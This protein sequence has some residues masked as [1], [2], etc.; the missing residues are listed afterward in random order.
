[1]D[2]KAKR[3][4][5]LNNRKE[6]RK[7]GVLLAA[8]EAFKKNGID[9]TKISEIANKAEIGVASVYRYFPTKVDLAIAA[10]TY[11]LDDKM[12]SFYHQF[13]DSEFDKHSGIENVRSILNIFL[14][15]Y[16]N[17]PEYI[18]FLENFD[19]YVIK[20]KIDFDKLQ[21]YEQSL[22]DF[23]AVMFK[24]LKKGKIEGSINKDIDNEIFYITTTHS[25]MSLC[26]KLISRGIIIKSDDQIK[27]E[28]Q[29]NFLIDMAIKYLTI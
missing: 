16:T 26:Q 13:T 25:L 14:E 12:D 7:V 15:M 21:N 20:E 17:Y 8:I 5:E 24:A 27:G 9:N 28:L 2:L 6:Q 1:M 19:N 18:G 29:I 3:K 10:A 11:L 23:E 22:T 4:L